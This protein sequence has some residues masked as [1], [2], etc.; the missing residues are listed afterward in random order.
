MVKLSHRKHL[1]RS[2][3]RFN[4]G[5][6]ATDFEVG[7]PDKRLRILR[8]F[9]H[10]MARIQGAVLTVECKTA[11]RLCARKGYDKS[12]NVKAA[13]NLV[14]ASG[15][16]AP[17]GET[18]KRPPRLFDAPYRQSDSLVIEPVFAAAKVKYSVTQNSDLKV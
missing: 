7:A 17:R 8:Y 4:G 12:E 14:S 15:G 16:K 5:T 2:R 6:K 9:I 3:S 18:R 13:V 11:S 10:T 1:A